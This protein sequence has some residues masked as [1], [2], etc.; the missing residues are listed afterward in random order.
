M[1]MSKKDPAILFYT[2]D[3]IVG[4]MHMTH[5]ERG[6]YIMLLC[7]QHQHGGAIEAVAFEELAGESKLIRSKFTKG[8]DG[9]YNERLLDEMG[10]RSERSKSMSK[11]AKKRWLQKQCKS[12]ANVMQLESESEVSQSSQSNK[13]SELRF[14]EIW[15]RYPRKLGRKE[16]LRHFKA[17]V[18]NEEDLK[19]INKALDNYIADIKAK[20][21]EDRF[22]KHGSAWFNNWEDWVN[23]EVYQAPK[24]RTRYDK[25]P[26]DWEKE[27]AKE[28]RRITEAKRREVGLIL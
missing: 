17:T 27:K 16:A 25:E 10:K 22:I 14:N 21:T 19:N 1:S 24:K 9:Y 28:R 18:K 8:E 26:E 20:G 13:L 3:F 12:N 11:N 2:Q 6:R 5:E 7:S 23:R 4:T 15:E